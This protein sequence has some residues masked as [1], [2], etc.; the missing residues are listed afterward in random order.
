MKIALLF[1][2]Y[3]SQFVGMG[4]ELYDEHRVVQEYFEEASNCLNVNFVKL[5]FASSD[6]ELSQMEHAY[7]ALF[8][9]SSALYALLKQEGILPQVVAGYNQGEYAALFAAGSMNFPDGLYLLTKIRSFYQQ[10]LETMSVRIIQVKGMVST[11]L[12]QLCY[13]TSTTGEFVS[14]SIYNTA[15]DCI[16]AGYTAAV[17]KMYKV[18]TQQK[19]VEILELGIEVGM[20]SPIMNTVADQFRI[21]LEKVDFKDVG[22]PLISCSNGSLITQ[23]SEIKNH[24]VHHITTA[25]KWTQIMNA[26]DAYDFIIEVGPGTR[27]STMVKELYPNKLYSAINTRADIETVQKIISEHA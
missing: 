8:L 11:E 19:E 25:M 3:G 23:A 12:E 22:I 16:V 21:Y 10:E 17:D 7:P 4:K 6:V 13:E 15:T 14:I 27:L 26:L 24:I 5:C 1:P 20:S 9:V 2:G 18:L